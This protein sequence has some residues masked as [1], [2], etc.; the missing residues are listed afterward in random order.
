[1]A[2][3]F[4]VI[5]AV[6]LL[7]VSLTVAATPA[8]PGDLDSS[9]GQG[10]E[11]TVQPNPTC[12]HGC[13]EFFGSHAQALAIEP[14]GA[15]MLVGNGSSEGP[16]AE[17]PWLARLDAHGALDTSFGDRGY[18]EGIPGLQMSRVF[19]NPDGDIVVLVSGHGGLGL[20]LERFTAAGVLDRSF[21]ARGVRWLAAPREQVEAVVDGQR[22]VVVLSRRSVL[23]GA[24]VARF[25]S[26]GA[27]DAAFGRHGI[28]DVH[29]MTE[30]QPVKLATEGDGGVVIVGVTLIQGQ[31]TG[32]GLFSLVRLT[33]AGRLDR[34]FGKQGVV[35]VSHALSSGVDAVAVGPRREVLLAG[36]EK[37]ERGGR[38]EHELAVARYTSKGVLDSSF[39]VRGV[40]HTRFATG[41][42]TVGFAAS[43]IAFEADGDGI[44]VGNSSQ[45]TVDVPRGMWFLA[46]YTSAGRDCSFGNQGF[47]EGADGAANAVTIEPDERIVIAGRGPSFWPH[48]AGT[49][50]MAARYIGGGR[51]RTCPGEPGPRRAFSSE[52]LR[53]L[54]A[55]T[56]RRLGLGH[57][58]PDLTAVVHRGVVGRVLRQQQLQ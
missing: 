12:A 17:G 39:G 28:A 18:A 37:L 57:A 9:F 48:G 4:G 19:I 51:P 22:R 11:A 29:A 10:G 34:S 44:V 42:R 5:A 7:S 47:V 40:A 50:F 16:G 58:E 53:D 27:P 30:A 3:L 26:S 8:V 49:A 38:R 23:G 35:R 36:G 20:G 52:A 32:T 43:A 55:T 2:R 6:A 25:L 14:N 13:V 1:V 31:P 21:G 41:P 45:P 15:V 54:A 46:R 24:V 33:A 56:W